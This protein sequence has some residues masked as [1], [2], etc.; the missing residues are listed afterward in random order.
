V[1]I[2]Q[3]KKKKTTQTNKQANK[4]IKNTQ[5]T[6]HRTQKGQQAEVPKWGCL[7]PTWEREESNHNWRSKRGPGGE[8]GWGWGMVA[9]EGNLIWYWVRKK[10]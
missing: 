4:T 3:K 7:S 10:D 6:V 8:T 2:S 9:K 1:Y 5:Y